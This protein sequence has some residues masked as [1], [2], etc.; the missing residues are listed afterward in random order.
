MKKILRKK[1]FYEN[2][3]QNEQ[4]HTSTVNFLIREHKNI[5]PSI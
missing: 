3:K 2:E 1:M 5:R 4:K